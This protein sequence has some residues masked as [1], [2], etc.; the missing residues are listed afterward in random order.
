MHITILTLFPNM[1]EGPFASSIISRAIKQKII[2]IQYIN[3]RDFSQDKYKTV[4]EHPYGG[5]AGMVM[6]VD[7]ADRAIAYAKSQYPKKKSCVVLLDPQGK[8]YKQ[9]DAQILSG[10]EHLIF[11]CAH[12]EGIDERI[13]TFVDAEYSIGDYILTG[14]EIPAM[15]LV[16]SIVRLIPGVL[17]KPESPKNESFSDPNLLEGPQY[18]NPQSYNGMNV[19]TILLSG[20]HKKIEEWKKEEAIKTTT[21]RRSDL[22]H[23]ITPD[24][25]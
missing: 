19:P 4:D 5:G 21:L 17:G 1:F 18:T 12:Y 16:D 7:V 14:G 2:T 11:F 13:R 9:A 15:V 23:I 25:S 6:K 24:I 3:I 22:G 8:Q 20:N 10:Y